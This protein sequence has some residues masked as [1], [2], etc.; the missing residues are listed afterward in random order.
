MWRDSSVIPGGR[1]G[2]GHHNFVVFAPMTMTFGTVVELVTVV[3]KIFS[4]TSLL[5]N[6]DVITRTYEVYRPKL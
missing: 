3:T 5:R 2:G 4:K 1:Q 6:N